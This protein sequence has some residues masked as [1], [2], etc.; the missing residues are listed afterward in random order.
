[1]PHHDLHCVAE[2]FR[3]A[4]EVAGALDVLSGPYVS[5]EVRIDCYP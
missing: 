4:N 3:S 1:M 2:A 5:D